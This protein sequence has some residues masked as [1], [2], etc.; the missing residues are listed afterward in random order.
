MQFLGFFKFFFGFYGISETYGFKNFEFSSKNASKSQ[1]PHIISKPN[2]HQI[3]AHLKP[4]PDWRDFRSFDFLPS[5][6][7]FADWNRPFL[8]QV[9]QFDVE[10]PAFHVEHREDLEISIFQLKNYYSGTKI[11]GK[12][13]KSKPEQ[14]E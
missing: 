9:D 4:R 5:N 12:A 6:R 1:I 7:D 11:V 3:P 14:S 2:Q 13:R 8:A 10:R